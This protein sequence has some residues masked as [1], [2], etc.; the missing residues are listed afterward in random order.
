MDRLKSV[1]LPLGI[2]ML[3]GAATGVAVHLF[4]N[5]RQAKAQAR[6]ES[7]ILSL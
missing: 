7:A 6:S 4:K 5:H 1:V 2:T 3:F